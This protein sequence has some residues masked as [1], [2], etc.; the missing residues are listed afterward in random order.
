MNEWNATPQVQADVGG[1]ISG[2]A[3][4]TPASAAAASTAA[5]SVF[6]L[7]RLSR[8]ELIS[9]AIQLTPDSS[10]MQHRLGKFTTEQLVD[11]IMYRRAR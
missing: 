1:W 10:S 11:L 6:E 4:S 2:P 3:S 8:A 9:Q 7:A 5:P